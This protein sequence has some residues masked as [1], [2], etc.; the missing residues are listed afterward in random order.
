MKRLS[1]ILSAVLVA[2]GVA[3]AGSFSQSD[4]SFAGHKLH[5]KIKVVTSFPDAKIQYVDSFPGVP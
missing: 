5:G 4:C 1:V 3:W 2:A